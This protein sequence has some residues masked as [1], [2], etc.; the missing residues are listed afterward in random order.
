MP[1]YEYECEKCGEK[2]EKF[3]SINESGKTVPCPAC[4]GKDVHKVF[5]AFGISGSVSGCSTGSS[6]AST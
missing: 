6:G 3:C 5:S 2:F 1:I 4:G